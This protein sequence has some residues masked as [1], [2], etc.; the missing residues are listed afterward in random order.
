MIYCI[1]KINVLSYTTLVGDIVSKIK[2]KINEYILNKKLNEFT[3]HIGKCT[4]ENGKLTCFV[5][6]NIFEKM[7][8]D[9][10]FYIKN[11]DLVSLKLNKLITEINYVFKDF[12]FH[13]KVY[14]SNKINK[15]LLNVNVE[16]IDCTFFNRI[17]VF[18]VSNL[19]FDNCKQKICYFVE[20]L[21]LHT[22]GIKKTK[23]NNSNFNSS[24]AY[25]D[26]CGISLTSKL[27]EISNTEIFDKSK[28]NIVTNN[29]ILNN[30]SIS[31]KNKIDISSYKIDYTNSNIKTP[32]LIQIHTNS[33]IDY[34]KLNSPN[35]IIN[36]VTVKSLV[37]EKLILDLLNQFN[38]IME[39]SNKESIYMMYPSVLED[40]SKK[41]K[42]LENLLIDLNQIKLLVENN[43]EIEINKYKEELK[44][45][46]LT[47]I[48]KK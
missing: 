33:F 11:E 37:K 3:N 21:V 10:L 6:K 14:I 42:L 27:V 29:L 31:S 32:Y 1:Y 44:N 41:K 2:D 28:V 48:I 7:I 25:R 38:K 40:I 39:K 8:E 43:F 16:F 26:E 34:K 9:E 35:I 13:N 30:S 19:L 24:M 46:S 22:S 5:E 20:K 47:K 45:K 4:Y 15:D 12:K 36:G 18:D 17:I 23:F